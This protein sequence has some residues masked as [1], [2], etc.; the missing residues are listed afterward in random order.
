[1]GEPQ[2]DYLLDLP[3]TWEEFR[4]GLRRN[5]RESLRHCYNSL[6]RDGHAYRLC[7]SSSPA[8]VREAVGRFLRL[9]ALR[10][11]DTA[12]VSHPDRFSSNRLREF[13]L[14]TTDRLARRAAVRVFELEIGGEV[15][16]SRIG[17]LAGDCLYF[18]YSGFDPAWSR[19][20][21]MT[22]TLAEAIRYA[23]SQGIRI[24]N[25]SP[26]TDVGKTRWGPRCLTLGTAVQVHPSLRARIARAI[27]DLA[28]ESREGRA[29][30]LMA[31]F[32]GLRRDWD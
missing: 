18:Y 1:M 7:V 29:Q 14:D 11:R 8:E 10:A 2:R 32:P 5:I 22:T 17:F 27:F 20:S 19:Y 30:W 12:G 26:G 4:A 3:P 23:I 24:V 21:V 15:V 25:L 16:A 28:G 9:H 31:G 13:L 6:A